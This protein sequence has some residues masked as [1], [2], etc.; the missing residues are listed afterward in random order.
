MEDFKNLDYVLYTKI[1]ANIEN[2]TA[3]KLSDLAIESAKEEAGKQGKDGIGYLVSVKKQGIET[4][5]DAQK[6]LI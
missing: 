6:T 1:G 4:L 2:P 3:E 5:E